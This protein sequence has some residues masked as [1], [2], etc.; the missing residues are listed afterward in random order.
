MVWFF[1]AYRGSMVWASSEARWSMVWCTIIVWSSCVV[2]VWYS[3]IWYGLVWFRLLVWRQQPEM[4]ESPLPHLP[5]PQT[6]H[7]NKQ[8]IKLKAT[9]IKTEK[10]LHVDSF[11]AMQCLRIK[12]P[13]WQSCTIFFGA[14]SSPWP[15]ICYKPRQKIFTL[16]CTSATTVSD[17]G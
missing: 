17:S 7:R 6:L 1:G 8:A 3:M 4:T 11:C 16:P 15:H 5:R 13:R 2:I 10:K 14:I 12:L 9:S